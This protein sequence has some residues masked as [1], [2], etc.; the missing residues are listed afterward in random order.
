MK[1]FMLPT[2]HRLPSLITLQKQPVTN[3]LL[4]KISIEGI[5]AIS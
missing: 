2:A 3:D 1:F 4:W 5:F